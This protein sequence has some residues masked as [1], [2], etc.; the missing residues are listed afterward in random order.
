LTHERWY[1]DGDLPEG[2]V[3]PDIPY[4]FESLQFDLGLE[5]GVGF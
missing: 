3:I 4:D 2:F 1:R 5:A